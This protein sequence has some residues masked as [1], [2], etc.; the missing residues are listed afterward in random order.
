MSE[1]WERWAPFSAIWAHFSM[2]TCN[3]LLSDSNH[4]SWHQLC[5][6]IS[7]KVSYWKVSLSRSNF[8]LLLSTFFM[9]PQCSFSSGEFNYTFSHCVC[10]LDQHQCFHM[11]HPISLHYFSHWIDCGNFVMEL[12][13]SQCGI[14]LAA[15]V[16]TF[17]LARGSACLCGLNWLM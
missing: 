1:A 13:W 7:L 11:P 12:F 8:S 14:S 3:C 15:P 16:Q 6:I 2:E 5:S 10:H 4:I 9:K 17:I